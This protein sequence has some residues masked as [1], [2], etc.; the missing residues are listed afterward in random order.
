[1]PTGSPR[2]WDPPDVPFRLR[3]G[4]AKNNRH[5]RIEPTSLYLNLLFTAVDLMGTSIS[6]PEIDIISNRRA[7]RLLFNWIQGE[8]DEFR[9]DL[10][11]LGPRTLLLCE[12]KQDFSWQNPGYGV[13]F[14][15]KTTVP[16]PGTEKGLEHTRIVNY[17]RHNAS[18][19]LDNPFNVQTS[20]R[21]S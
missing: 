19:E 12:I 13:V 3:W 21:T 14:E 7:L 17:V 5:S 4:K 6:W 9:I 11:P 20:N 18:T 15:D 8:K 10:Q 16:V 1:M 2:V